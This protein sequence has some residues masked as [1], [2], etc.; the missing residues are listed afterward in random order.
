M[1][2]YDWKSNLLGVSKSKFVLWDVVEYIQN[3]NNRRY[4]IIFKVKYIDLS[5]F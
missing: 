2:D 1:N 4:F 5:L 3:N